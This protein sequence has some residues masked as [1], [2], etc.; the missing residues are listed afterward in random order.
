[1][2]SFPKKSVQ[3]DL[4][5]SEIKLVP[6]QAVTIFCIPCP[7]LPWAMQSIEQIEIRM[8]PHTCQIEIFSLTNQTVKSFSDWYAI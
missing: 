4:D 8:I 3:V 1:M 5:I 6:G 2:N 7:H